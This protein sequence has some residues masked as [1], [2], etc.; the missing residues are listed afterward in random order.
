MTKTVFRVLGVVASLIVGG[1]AMGQTGSV[2]AWGN[3]LY[4]QCDIPASANNGVSA[5]AG[6]VYHTIALKNGAVLAWGAGTTN[7][8]SS[9]N[10]GQ[11]IIPTAAQS[12]VSAIASGEVHSI[13]LKDGA[14][15]AWGDNSKGQCNIPASANSDVS[16]IAGGGDH[17]IALKG[18]AV[19][20]WGWNVFGQCN[21][22]GSANSGVTAIA[23]GIYHTIALKGGAV[24]AWGNNDY[25]QCTIPA[26]ALSGVSAIAGGYLHTIALKDGAVLAW[27]PSDSSVNYGQ[28]TIPSAAQSGVSAIAGG[29]LHTIALKG[30]AVLAWGA[31]TTNTSNW[32]D[33]GQCTSPAAALSGVTAIACGGIHTV[34]LKV[35][36]PNDLDGDGVPN[37]TD[38]CPSVANPTQADC[39][40]NGMG[41]A[42][43]IQL[44]CNHN[45]LADVCEILSGAVTDQNLNGIPDTCEVPSVSRVLP[46]SGPS[47][48]GTAVRIIGINFFSALPVSVTFGGAPATN[49][50][51]VSLTEITAVT[52]SGSPGDTVVTVN[53]ASAE[54]FYFRPSCDGDL[55]NNGTIDS[56]D[57]GL[58]LLG[59]G[60]CS[61]SLTTPQPEPMIFQTA[62]IATP[63]LNKK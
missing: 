38:N 26:A 9:A 41:D 7:T 19:L 52:P 47:T 33:Y 59:F 62:E 63:V 37:A 43:E 48:G 51:V 54:A 5:M 10:Y 55:D 50:V 61:E 1:A 39:D 42:C 40:S 8:G 28:C 53:G 22:P 6:G 34:A 29:Y 17:T 16:A 35:T 12:G 46:I 31:G 25:G 36:D 30:G 20:A 44:D 3:N 13:A 15:L 45:G 23:G 18:G 27:G 60:S 32:P 2:V 58:V 21:I 4:G 11:S 56:A 49:V 57:L 24:L 14:V